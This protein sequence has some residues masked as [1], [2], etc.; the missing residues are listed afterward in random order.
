MNYSI[1]GSSI[2]HYLL[3]FA[4]IHVHR[5]GDAIQSSHPLSPPSPPALNFPHH[6]AFHIRWP[7]YWSFS[8]NPSN[9]YSGL[10][11]F[12]I[13]WFDLLVIQGTLKSIL[14]VQESKGLS[15]IT[16]RKHQFFGAQLSLESSSH[17][18]TWPPEKPQP[19]PQGLIATCCSA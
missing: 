5:V 8:F 7:K 1:P 6:Q 13:D 3:E 18:H 9:E 4:Q 12:R 14:L 16:V 17:I 19:S 15:S 2:I 10:I 11:S